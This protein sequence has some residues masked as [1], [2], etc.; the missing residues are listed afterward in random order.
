MKIV[1]QESKRR[2]LVSVSASEI[3]R[4]VGNSYRHEFNVGDSIDV[5]KAYKRL[6][7]LIERRADLDSARK[8]LQGLIRALDPLEPLVLA[9]EPVEDD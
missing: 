2:F 5:E 8:R 4:I 7:A 3:G 9:G 6:N 1:A